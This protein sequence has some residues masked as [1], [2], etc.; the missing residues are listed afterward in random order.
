MNEIEINNILNLLNDNQKVVGASKTRTR[1]EIE[2][3]YQL[4]IRDFGEN[5]VQELIQK[6]K[7]NDIVIKKGSNGAPFVEGI[8]GVFVSISHTKGMVACAFADSRIGIDAETVSMRRK[9]V[10]KRVFTFDES[11][12]LDSSEDENKRTITI[13]PYGKK[14]EEICEAVLWKFYT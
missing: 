9:S 8:D 4:G 12:L 10:E 3:A 13:T 11:R 5:Y 1:E 2:K 7:E 6:Y 14:Y